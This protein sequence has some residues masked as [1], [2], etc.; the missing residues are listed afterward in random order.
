MM[1]RIVA[2]VISSLVLVAAPASAEIKLPASSV[3]AW[4]S[5]RGGA[6]LCGA[7]PIRARK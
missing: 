7:L 2:I 6:C 4:S 3:T 5:S 1:R